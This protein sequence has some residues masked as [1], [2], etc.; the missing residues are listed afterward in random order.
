MCSLFAGCS[1]RVIQI[2]SEPNGAIVT[3]ND[4]ELGRTP[5]ETEFTYY[6]DYDVRLRKAGYE[7][8]RTKQTAWTP[9]YER[10][11]LDLASSAIPYEHV[12]KWHFKL[13]PTREST[14]QKDQFETGLITRA[15]DLRGQVDEPAPAKPASQ[16][17][18][19]PENA[20]PATPPGNPVETTPP[21]PPPA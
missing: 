6:G 1:Q 13:E 18:P 12:V 5:L 2:T 15:K 4:V 3:L 21:P 10:V 19:A 16:S 14:E 20:E 7:P 8:L 17:P 11:P 9:L